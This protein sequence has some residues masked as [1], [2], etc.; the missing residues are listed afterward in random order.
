MTSLPK[1]TRAYGWHLLGLAALASLV[2]C[3]GSGEESPTPETSPTPTM[4]PTPAP[5]P[6]AQPVPAGCDVAVYPSS[7]DQTAVQEALISTTEGDVVCLVNGPFSFLGELSVDKANLTVRG[8]NNPVLNFSGQIAGGNAIH[9]ISDGFTIEDLTVHEPAGDGIRATAVNNVTFSN[10]KVIWEEARAENGGY[11]L[12]P[13]SSTGVVVEDCEVA[14]ASDAG[15]YVGQ[16]SMIYVRN[17]EVHDNVA[18][19][20]IENST[21]AEVSGNHCYDNTGGVLVFNLPTLPVKDGKRSRLFNNLLEHNNHENFAEEGNMVAIVPQGTGIMIMASDTNEV[22]DNE[23]KDNMSIGIA[24]IHYDT[25]LVGSYDDP[26]FDPFP[27]A[28]WVHDNVFENN[29]YAPKDMVKQLMLAKGLGPNATVPNM[30][31]DGCSDAAKNNEDG[32]LTNCYSSN[33][34]SD[35]AAADYVNVE[36]CEGYDAPPTYDIQEVNC[37]HDSLGPVE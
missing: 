10:V 30:I 15:V 3:S 14:G 6:T 1:V 11:G 8:I 12:Y 16:S 4:T 33:T 7:D 37:E 24:I 26:Q 19:I 28:N 34:G 21:D 32:H 18:G 27:E 29:G 9:A 13:V 25:T 35:G 17:N 31:W 23:V 2:A 36:L 5:T 22:Y 20:E